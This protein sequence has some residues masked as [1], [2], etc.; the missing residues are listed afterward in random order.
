MVALARAFFR[1]GFNACSGLSDMVL[2]EIWSG[3]AILDTFL[4]C[5]SCFACADEDE[6][7]LRFRRTIR[8]PR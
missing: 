7:P 8:S 3:G 4:C 1:G 2:A 5:S 6:R